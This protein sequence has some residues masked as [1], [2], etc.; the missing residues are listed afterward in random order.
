MP[1]LVSTFV[2]PPSA[3]NPL[4]VTGAECPPLRVAFAALPSSV[5]NDKYIGHEIQ[6]TEHIHVPPNLSLTNDY[7]RIRR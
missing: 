7:L 6:I 5:N 2:T 4:I 1:L 3:T